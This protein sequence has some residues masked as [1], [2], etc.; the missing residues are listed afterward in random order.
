MFK[1]TQSKTTYTDQEV[2]GLK[3]MCSKVGTRE[4]RTR[5]KPSRKK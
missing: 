4:S 1:R 2:K 3:T 5:E